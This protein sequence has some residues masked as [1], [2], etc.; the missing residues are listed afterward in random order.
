[1]LARRPAAGCE[2][3]RHDPFIGSAA[4]TLSPGGRAGTCAGARLRGD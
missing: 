2:K 1:V 4:Q 3:C